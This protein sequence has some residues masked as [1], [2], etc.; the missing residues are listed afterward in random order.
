MVTV[1]FGGEGRNADPKQQTCA[2]DARRAAGVTPNS[3]RSDPKQLTGTP[4][5]PLKI[6]LSLFISC[7]VIQAHATTSLR[8]LG[9]SESHFLWP[10]SIGRTRSKNASHARLSAKMK[11][12]N[13]MRLVLMRTKIV[14]ISGPK[15]FNFSPALGPDA[16]SGARIHGHN[17]GQETKNASHARAPK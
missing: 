7:L 14:M 15:C 4:R 12:K 5:P 8:H 2:A 17:Q 10:V 11:T 9:P 13:V 16:L 3:S 6:D 1:L